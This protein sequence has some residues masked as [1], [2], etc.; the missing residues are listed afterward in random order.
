MPQI[1]PGL[2]RTVAALKQAGL[3]DKNSSEHTIHVA[4]TNGKGTTAKA[5]EHFLKAA[6]ETVGLYTSPHLVT[7]RERIVANGEM[8]SEEEFCFLCEKHLPTIETFNLTHFE[9]LTLFALDYFLNIKKTKWM[10]FEIGLGGLWDAT[11][12]ITHSTS[13]ITTIGYDH[14]HILG[15]TLQE[16][17]TNKFG[18]IQ[19]DNLVIH[20][21]YPE[22]IDDL[23]T[24]TV[25]KQ[26][27]RS[28]QVTPLPFKVTPQL[29]PQYSLLYHQQE[30]PLS[31]PGARAVENISTAITAITQLGLNI[32]LEQ[33]LHSLSWPARM[34]RLEYKQSL[35]PIYLSGDH[36]LQGIDSLCEILN[37]SNY[38]RLRIILGL[39]K[40]RAHDP[41]VEKLSTLRACEIYFTQPQFQGVAPDKSKYSPYFD[42]PWSAL[43]KALEGFSEDDLIVVTGSLYLC[44]EVMA[45]T[46][47][48]E[49]T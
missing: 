22:E 9:C 1:A 10:I 47:R 25:K 16:I 39:S 15:N 17:A 33:A 20:Q 32:S 27:A 34:T 4:G 36:N 30:I 13:I 6:G 37:Y 43:K 40:N 28:V 8:I 42:S 35:C 29:I 12:A 2:E 18:I 31:L 41:F 48:E 3:F 24:A 26:Q 44:G 45:A 19:K 38:K 21:K 46:K 49:T 14:M 23:L 11:N 5:L 7:T